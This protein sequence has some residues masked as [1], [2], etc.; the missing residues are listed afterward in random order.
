[1]RKNNKP[2]ILNCV[3]NVFKP[4]LNDKDEN[5]NNYVCLFDFDGFAFDRSALREGHSNSQ[6]S[7]GGTKNT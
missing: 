3:D 4:F 6:K 7:Q 2:T 5:D 1:M